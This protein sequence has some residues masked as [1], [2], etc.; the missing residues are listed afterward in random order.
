MCPAIVAR[1]PTL[2]RVIAAAQLPAIMLSI[3]NDVPGIAFV[4]ASIA[5]VLIHE[6]LPRTPSR[7]SKG[8]G[9]RNGKR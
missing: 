7:K 8:K 6:S 5:I 4:F 9:Y 1:N 2:L 3:Q